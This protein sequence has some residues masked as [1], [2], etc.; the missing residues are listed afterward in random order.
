MAKAKFELPNGTVVQI[1]GTKEEIQ[2]ILTF[3]AR[4]TSERRSGQK[5][6]TRKKKRAATS[7]S[8]RRTTGPTSLILE[9]REEGFFK[10]KRKI[11]DIQK[12]LEEHG[13]IYALTS[14]TG[15]LSNLLKKREIRRIK[16]PNGW[17]YVANIR[18]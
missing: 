17:K 1:E 14:L 18:K 11:T 5:K 8:K 2:G 12:K 16:E 6:G 13:Y 10:S 9:L 7:I 15:P 3:Y 4:P